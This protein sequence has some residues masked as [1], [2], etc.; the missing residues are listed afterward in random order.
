MQAETQYDKIVG[1]KDEEPIKRQRKVLVL[2]KS[3]KNF[4]VPEHLVTRPYVLFDFN[5][6]ETVK[7]ASLSPSKAKLRKNKKHDR[8]YPRNSV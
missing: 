8:V 5:Y 7:V 2:V 4:K 1:D 6:K 3:V